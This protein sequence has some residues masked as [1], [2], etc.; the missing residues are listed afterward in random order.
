[1]SAKTAELFG[2]IFY[3]LSMA[4]IGFMHFLFRGLRQPISPGKAEISDMVAILIYIFGAYLMATGIMIML[5][6]KLRATSI[7][8][9]YIFLLFLVVGHLPIRLTD[10]YP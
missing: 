5:G 8:L 10:D 4:G 3:G 2:R 1:M 9:A 6:K 7:I